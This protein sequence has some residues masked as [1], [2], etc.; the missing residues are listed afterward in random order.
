MTMNNQAPRRGRPVGSTKPAAERRSH[1]LP[2]RLT[3]A[4]RAKAERIGGGNASRGLRLA[5]TA[6]SG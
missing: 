2:V 6:Y 1:N 4:E 5:L 3:A